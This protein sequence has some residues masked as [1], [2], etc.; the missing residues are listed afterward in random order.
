MEIKLDQVKTAHSISGVFLD[1]FRD[2]VT[3]IN[4]KLARFKSCRSTH[5][6]SISQSHVAAD[7]LPGG[8]I[9]G[10]QNQR[11]NFAGLHPKGAT[12]I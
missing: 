12:Q 3:I 9:S 2:R 5:L 4:I 1:F 7:K 10:C 8:F 11:R 6:L